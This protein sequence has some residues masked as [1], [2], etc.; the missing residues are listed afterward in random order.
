MDDNKDC[1]LLRIIYCR[2]GHTVL[3]IIT[4]PASVSPSDLMHLLGGD[5]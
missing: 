5:A 4:E 2:C 3:D 1:R